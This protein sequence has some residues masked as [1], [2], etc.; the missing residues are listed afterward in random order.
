METQSIYE[1]AGKV[2]SRTQLSAKSNLE[3][4]FVED[5]LLT[6]E[7]PTMDMRVQKVHIRIPEAFLR[8]QSPSTNRYAEETR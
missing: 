4:L 6:S 3:S 2:N 5:R 7:K 8:P 1:K